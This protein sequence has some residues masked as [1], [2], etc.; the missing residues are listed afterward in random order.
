[1]D[2]LI[3]A[4]ENARRS[5]QLEALGQWPDGDTR[6]FWSLLVEGTSRSLEGV[7][8]SLEGCSSD[9]FDAQSVRVEGSS[10]V[11]RGF[12]HLIGPQVGVPCR[13]R[14]DLDPESRAHVGLEIAWGSARHG[15]PARAAWRKEHAIYRKPNRW[16]IRATPRGIRLAPGL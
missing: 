12:M 4:Y 14:F 2:E 7:F 5:E 9:G 8:G 3:E 1:M 11:L 13:A 15:V 6:S 16:L 10:L